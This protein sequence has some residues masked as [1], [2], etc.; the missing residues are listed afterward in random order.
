MRAVSAKVAF[1]KAATGPFIAALLAVACRGAA[2]QIDPGLR[3]ERFLYDVLGYVYFWELDDLIL[4]HTREDRETEIWIR[5]LEPRLDPGDRSHFAEIWL[6]SLKAQ[7]ELKKADYDIPELGKHVATPNYRVLSA[8]LL[9][10]APAGAEAYAVLRLPHDQ[11][12]HHM[13]DARNRH[14]P[15]PPALRERVIRD[16]RHLAAEMPRPPD[17]R[18]GQ[19]LYLAPR[20]PVCSDIWIYWDNTRTAIRISGD[21]DPDDKDIDDAFPLHTRSYDLDAQVVQTLLE[22][23]TSGAY[24]TKDLAGRVLYQCIV[25]GEEVDLPADAFAFRK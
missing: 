18:R 3:D 13:F 17:D 11:V 14:K 1:L 21:M 25:L 4:S 15:L 19:V 2:P 12:L 24:I 20:S 22:V 9:P 10:G 5:P 6:P 8:T 23:E 16:V 7:V